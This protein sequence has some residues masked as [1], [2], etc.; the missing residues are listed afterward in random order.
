MSTPS[1]VKGWCPGARRP[2]QSGDGLIVRIR[3]YGGS[4]PV[5]SLSVLAGAAS[6]F[7]NGQIDLTRRANLQIRGVTEL[8]LE[9]LW[10]ALASLGLLDDS[11]EAEAIRNVAVNPL[12]GIDPTEIIDVRPMAQA[13]AS[14]LAA[15]ADLQALPGKF[16]FVID[17]CG[18][19]P[20][21]ELAA[22]VRLEARR[23]GAD[24]FVAVG[25]AARNGVT[26]LSTAA[27]SEAVDVAVQIARAILVR[28]G[29]ERALALSRQA[30]NVIKTE[31]GLP[32]VPADNAAGSSPAQ[33]RRGLLALGDERYVVGLGAAFGRI[34]GGT[35]ASFAEELARLG[36]TDIRLSPWR[37]VYAEVGNR[38]DGEALIAVGRALGLVVDDADPLVRI[39]ACSGAGGCNATVLPTHDHGRLLA[40]LAARAGFTGTVHVSGCPKGCARSA[41]ADLVLIG[42]GDSY[43]VVR[44]GTVRD[45]PVGAL[46]A[47]EIGTKGIELLTNQ[48][49]VH[50]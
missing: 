46:A 23:D 3:P 40:G 30:V 42:A 7:G 36:V 16:A 13:L 5:A 21:T 10:D 9:P 43:R 50:A 29:A 45:E 24:I 15:N 37:T 19:L 31:L 48:T 6:R 18:L 12:T 22:D 14:Q 25:V 35:L 39:D 27:P 34:E 17:G 1:S 8:A 33:P 38:A 2:M 26:W 47:S 28:G 44:N 32:D 11:A 4:L 41:A 20:L 49:A